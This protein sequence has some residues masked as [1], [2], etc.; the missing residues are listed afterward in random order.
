MVWTLLW[1]REAVRAL[2]RLPQAQAKRLVKKL[3]ASAA[4]PRRH[5]TRLS[6]RGDY[7]L[8]IGDYRILALLNPSKKTL[9][10]EALGHRKRIY[11]K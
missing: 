4:D 10:V 6:G 1:S 9:T 3:E 11:R 8:S 5:F 7:K 2:S